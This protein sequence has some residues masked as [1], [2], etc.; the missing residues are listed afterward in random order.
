MDI[1]ALEKLYQLKEKG[2]ISDSEFQQ[3]KKQLL[4]N[5]ERIKN[6]YNPISW[7]VIIFIIV[8]IVVITIIANMFQA[9]SALSLLQG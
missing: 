1:E 2:I 3:Q 5:E 7:S 8:I 9:Y 4:N 6:N